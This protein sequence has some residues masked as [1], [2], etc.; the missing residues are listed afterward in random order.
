MF[1]LSQDII[2]ASSHQQANLEVSLEEGPIKQ[3]PYSPQGTRSS[4]LQHCTNQ[5]QCQ[6]IF[7]VQ[8]SLS[9]V[10]ALHGGGPVVIASD[11]FQRTGSTKEA[12]T[13]SATKGC[14]SGSGY[15]RNLS[16]GYWAVSSIQDLH[17]TAV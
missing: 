16:Q 5:H 7:N 15:H 14:A 9:A 12:F 2:P 13:L 4:L 17:V 8:T 11:E 10:P 1:I 6:I 3:V